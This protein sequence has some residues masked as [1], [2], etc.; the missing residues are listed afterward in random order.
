[1]TEVTVIDFDTA[2]IDDLAAYALENFDKKLDKRK[3]LTKLVAECKKLAGVEDDGADDEPK[4]DNAP[5]V[6]YHRPKLL[7][8][9]IK[10]LRHPT[11][12]RV[13]E[14]TQLLWKRGDMI[15]CDKKGQSVS[16]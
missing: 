16:G 3:G 13:H 4:D 15:P 12:N 10:Y 5:S 2:T 7:P 8:K 1:M 14:A 11:N 6:S 9:H